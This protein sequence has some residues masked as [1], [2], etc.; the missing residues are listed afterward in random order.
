[1]SLVLRVL[2][3]FSIGILLLENALAA[4][5]NIF[6]DK[7]EVAPYDIHAPGSIL[8]LFN[9]A[10][11]G[12]LL[13]INNKN[14][15]SPSHISK[16]HYD[17]ERKV[18]VLKLADGLTFH[19][20]RKVTS[21]DLEFSIL[22]GF[23][24][25]DSSFFK[26]YFGDI[27]GIENIKPGTKYKTGL[28]EGVRVVNEDVIEVKLTSPNPAF[29][30]SLTTP[31]FSLVPI[32]EL[33]SD[34]LTWKAKPVGAGEFKVISEFDG[35]KTVLKNEVNNQV[36][37]I[38][39]NR[40]DNIRFDISFVAGV[41]ANEKSYLSSRPAG[42][43]L[44]TISLENELSANPNFREGLKYLVDRSKFSNTKL[45]IAPLSQ[46]LP[47]PFWGRSSKELDFN[48]EKAQF[49]FSKIPKNL[50]NKVYEI[51][52][53][54]GDALSEKHLFYE[55]HLKD[56]FEQ[57]GFKIKFITNQ[58][59]FVSRKTAINAPLYSAAMV[60]DYIDPLVTFSAF[61][62][63]GHE[64]YYKVQKSL[65]GKYEELYIKAINSETFGER[66]E[67]VKELSRLT[68]DNLITLV[69]AEEKKVI[70]FNSKIVKSLGLQLYPLTL[71]LK[72]LELL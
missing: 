23:Y 10:V 54:A 3:I 46:L 29:F 21:Q 55:K 42:I 36:I 67:V 6:W 52:V 65:E 26:T 60:A 5:I 68:Q 19:N 13:S 47:T 49:Y 35:I 63:N 70:Y 71:D 66:L 58:E 59:K 51:P 30:H 22:R 28:I 11:R 1:M 12:Q 7:S 32:E 25:P 50:L 39:N 14:G 57:V 15:L 24:S 37:N 41:V 9:M 40:V 44:M 45:G 4:E 62:K 16:F 18:Y 61:R 33:K 43:R 64:K 53:F 56:Q 17:F 8:S 48:L 31:Y 27:V 2:K 69:L 34:Y 38:Y 72:Q 20:G